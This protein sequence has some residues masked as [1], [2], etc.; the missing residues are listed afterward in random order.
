MADAVKIASESTSN[1]LLSNLS[2]LLNDF[3][4]STEHLWSNE[5]KQRLGKHWYY[6]NH[7]AVP[8]DWL[9]FADVFVS[10]KDL[11]DETAKKSLKQLK[12]I[13]KDNKLEI[14]FYFQPIA[15]SN[16]FDSLSAEIIKLFYCRTYYGK[17]DAEEFA[18]VNSI[19]SSELKIYN[20]YSIEHGISKL[21]EYKTGSYGE[22]KPASSSFPS[23]P[24]L[25]EVI[26]HQ[27]N[28]SLQVYANANW[29]LSL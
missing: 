26:E 1:I 28:R 2:K 20:L 9:E 14:D 12:S 22:S 17:K 7:K 29:I 15:I 24:E 8:S 27:N 4:A 6:C 19:Y 21:C 5:L 10:L 18:R 11:L 16:N 25:K 3:I 13:I 23:I